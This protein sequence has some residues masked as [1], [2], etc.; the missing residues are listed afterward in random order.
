[1]MQW[2]WRVEAARSI[3]FGSWSG[4]QR[5][6]N[7]VRSLAGASIADITLSG[8][9]PELT[10]ALSNRRWLQSFMTA[11]GQPGWVVFLPT[12]RWL[13]VERARLVLDTQNVRR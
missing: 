5:I 13:C 12:K 9:L 2:S 11:E 6:T 8:R 7:G 4:E 3:R 10:V 1:M